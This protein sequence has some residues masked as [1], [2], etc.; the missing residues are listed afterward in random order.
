MTAYKNIKENL[1]EQRKERSGDYKETL[2]E[3]RKDPT[4]IRLDKPTN[5]PR[6][7]ALGYKAKQGFVVARV[8]VK[9]GS[10]MHSRPKSGRRP[11]RMGVNKLTRKKSKGMIAEERAQ[12]KFPNMEVLN[13]YRVCEDGKGVWFEVILVDPAH[14]RVQKDTTVSWTSR[15]K[16]RVHRGRTSTG[17]KAAGKR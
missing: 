9:R 1:Q 2:L 8:K 10:G 3:A 16:N 12:R 11:K 7:R 14:K 6:A 15:D 4:V 13:S 5:I 17:R